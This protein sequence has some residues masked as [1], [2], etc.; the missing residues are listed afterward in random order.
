MEHHDIDKYCVRIKCN[1][2]TGSG[3]IIP[4]GKL[5]YVLTAA[6]CLGEVAPEIENIKI[7]SQDSYASEF[8][9]IKCIRLLEFDN[10]NDLALVEIENVFFDTEETSRHYKFGIGF[11]SDNN[12]KFLGYQGVNNEEFRPF[13]AKVLSVSDDQDKFKITLQGLTFD[14]AG[15]NGQELAKGLSGSGV[16]IYKYDSPFLVG[17]LNSVITDRAWNDDIHCCSIKCLEKYIPSFVNLS[18][19]EYLKEW[20]DNIEK[21]RTEREIE[22]FKEENSDFFNKL[23]RKNKVLYPELEKANKVTVKQIR[24]YLTMSDNLSLINRDYPTLYSKIKEIVK[25]FVDSVED[26]YSRSVNES[27]EAVDLKMKLEEQLRGQFFL[28]PSLADIDLSTYQVIEWLGICTL[29]FT[30]ND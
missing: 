16:F 2:H 12:V 4:Q 21:K 3:V 30:K 25:K 14:Q 5:C 13:D 26:D 27:S 17:I 15:E 23:Y 22:R 6:H 7:E 1:E 20:N 19:F 18:D 29:N 11:L 24:K 8:E 28:L 9:D 10:S